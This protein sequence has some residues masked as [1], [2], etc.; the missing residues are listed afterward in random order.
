MGKKTKKKIARPQATMDFPNDEGVKARE[1]AEPAEPAESAESAA[2]E[3]WEIPLACEEVKDSE[4]VLEE[5][6]GASEPA[7]SEDWEVPPLAC[8]EVKDPEP[9]PE[10]FREAVEPAVAEGSEG[11]NMPTARGPGICE[12]DQPESRLVK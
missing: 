4:P 8:E 9:I 6:V 3:D 5:P 12:Y 2:V 10:E 1:P 7:A 11:A